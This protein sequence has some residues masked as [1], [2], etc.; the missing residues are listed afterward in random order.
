VQPEIKVWERDFIR[1]HRVARLAT[2]GKSGQP[3]LVPI[4]YAF[5]GELI[6]TP[7]D[8]KPKRVEAEQLQRVRDIQAQPAAAVLI[9]DFFEDWKRLVWV[10]IRG[11]A[12]LVT[13]GERYTTGLN[14][15]EAKYPQYRDMPIQG[16]PLIV[17]EIERV[18]SWMGS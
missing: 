16:R 14:L 6:Y 4:V 5:D 2:T 10:Q 1:E 17:V 18:L 13:S 11:R 8:E 12:R 3:H 9:D 15:L 7:I